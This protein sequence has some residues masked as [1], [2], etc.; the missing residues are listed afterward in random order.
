MRTNLIVLILIA[1]GIS[2]CEPKELT[3]INNQGANYEIVIPENPDELEMKS[4]NELQKHLQLM[5]GTKL[6]ITSEGEASTN[7]Q[8]WIGNTSHS[9]S[10]GI[11]A[12]EIII[13]TQDQNIILAGG[14]PTSTLYTVYTFLK[15]ILDADFIHQMRK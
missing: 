15:I 11:T 13:K 3:L 1:L 2:A 14:D 10:L 7:H 4:A 6:Q 5:T 8:I 12:N 9:Q